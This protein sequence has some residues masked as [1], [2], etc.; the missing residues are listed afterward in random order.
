MFNL[1]N[2]NKNDHYQGLLVRQNSEEIHK[3]YLNSI[4]R[5]KIDVYKN[6]IEYCRKNNEKFVDPDF[7]PCEQ[8]LFCHEKSNKRY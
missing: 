2:L 6:I 3:V 8:S 1:E 7:R 5:A 4:E